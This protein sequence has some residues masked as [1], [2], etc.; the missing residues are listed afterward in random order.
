MTRRRRSGL[1]AAFLACALFA[2]SAVDASDQRVPDAPVGDVAQS[3]PRNRRVYMVA[4]SVALGAVQ[5]FPRAFG[6]DWQV[7]VD[8]SP[9]LFIDV[10]EQRH[11]RGRMA[12]S[13][14]VFGDHAIVAGGYNYPYW[15]PPRF[16]RW[17][18]SIVGAFREAGVKHIYWITLREVDP[19][20]I[21]AGAWRQIQPYYWYFPAVN[22]HLVRAL[23]RHPDL[24]LIDWAAIA[25]RTGLT[26]D[27]IHLNTTGAAEFAAMVR[28]QVVATS[29]RVAAGSVTRIPVPNASETA[30]VTVNLTT[31]SPRTSGFLTAYPCGGPA[32]V[33]S[34]S[35]YVRDQVVAA[36]ALVPVGADGHIC[37]ASHAATNLIVDITGGFPDGAGLAPVQPR[38]LIDT[39]RS[40]PA[41]LH[42]AGVPLRVKVAGIDGV[43]SD[44]SAVALSVTATSAAGAGFVN[45]TACGR[46]A[47]NTSNVNFAPGRSTPN[48]VVVEPGTNGEVCLVANTA[49][50]LIVDLFAS[51]DATA[52]LRL[53]T[54]RRALDT[55]NA[56]RPVE[57]GS[58]TVVDLAPHGVA[59]D[60]T[61]VLVNLTSTGAWSPG[62]LTAY[63]CTAPRPTA[64]NLNPAPGRTVANFAIVRPDPSGRIC[65]YSHERT[66]IIVDVS[67][68]T[69]ATFSGA[70][71]VR[72]LDTRLRS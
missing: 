29:S 20:Y 24:T 10:M 66:H 28:S 7:T 12:T 6:P 48:L 41:M 5:A 35:N 34:N 54:P 3:I 14:W 11:V 46:G 18:D 2:S 13:P 33:A 62:F 44:A 63:P 45:V 42:P 55:R 32:P 26:Y 67:G 30:A 16:D 15:D 22:E 61:G 23:A 64:S 43:P 4:D 69:G 40:S 37:V 25:N 56:G 49:V 8:G 31:T 72:L 59:R 53:T 1:A 9:A 65:I 60:A 39:R 38:R 52:D 19:Q 58:V 70:A 47:T 36:T 17:I 51:F 27:A 71:P 21:S 57:P 68:S 50:E